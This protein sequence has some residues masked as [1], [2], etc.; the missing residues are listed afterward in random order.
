MLHKSIQ[1][2]LD[3]E[4]AE[5]QQSNHKYELQLREELNEKKKIINKADDLSGELA[6]LKSQ[7]Q[8]ENDDNQ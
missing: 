8:R 7:M 6:K 3:Q 5:H 2:A 4:K 1:K